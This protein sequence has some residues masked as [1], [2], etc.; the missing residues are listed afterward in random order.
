[1]VIHSE[2]MW[3]HSINRNKE[4]SGLEATFSSRGSCSSLLTDS[5]LFEAFK[6]IFDVQKGNEPA[7]G[8]KNP[9]VKPD[10]Y[11]LLAFKMIHVYRIW[12]YGDY[13]SSINQM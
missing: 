12:A 13:L 3:A 7:N 2:S 9:N 5:F 4:I 10:V 6:C 1:M 8:V 11:L